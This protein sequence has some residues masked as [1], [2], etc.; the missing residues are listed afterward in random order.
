MTGGWSCDRRGDR[1]T[2]KTRAGLFSALY[3]GATLLEVKMLSCDESS[4]NDQTNDNEEESV[5]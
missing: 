4:S 1:G 5:A 2:I 3:N